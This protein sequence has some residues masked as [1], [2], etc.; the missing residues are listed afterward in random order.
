VARHREAV[1]PLRE[2]LDHVVSLGLAVDEHVDAQILLQ[3]DDLPD[4]GA[5]RLPVPGLVDVAAGEGRARGADG[6]SL[7]EGAD[8]RRRQEGEGQAGA[9]PFLP[10]GV[11]GPAPPGFVD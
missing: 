5:D 8:R 4:L 3:A 7:R 1:E 2:I 6:R 11:V 9:L 10:H